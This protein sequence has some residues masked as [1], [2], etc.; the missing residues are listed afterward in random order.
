MKQE[1]LSIKILKPEP[2]IIGQECLPELRLHQKS[3]NACF[4]VLLLVVHF[5]LPVHNHLQLSSI[6]LQVTA[7]FD[8]RQKD[9]T[10]HHLRPLHVNPRFKASSSLY[11]SSLCSSLV[12]R[13]FRHKALVLFRHQFQTY[14]I[15]FFIIDCKPGLL[16]ASDP[17]QLAL[18]F[19][20][21]HFCK[22]RFYTGGL[23]LRPLA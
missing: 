23:I 9:D 14:D 20:S 21:P 12:P 2:N 11:W 16:V 13:F 22:R 5:L 4:H 7:S 19:C 8:S 15:I 18:W 3:G 1:F 10:G 17:F 6:T